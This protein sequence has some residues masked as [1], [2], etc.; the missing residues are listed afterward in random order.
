MFGLWG[1]RSSRLD[2]FCGMCLLGLY[3]VFLFW[4]V[5]S[6]LFGR[7]LS[8]AGFGVCIFGLLG[9]A[10]IPGD[11]TVVVFGVLRLLLGLTITLFLLLTILLLVN[12]FLEITGPSLNLPLFNFF[13]PCMIGSIQL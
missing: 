4:N 10:L 7:F 11:I 5:P 6:V 8:M 2:L 3:R 9:L 1:C 12:T 13:C